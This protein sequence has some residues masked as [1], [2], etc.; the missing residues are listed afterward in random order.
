MLWGLLPVSR[1]ER[2]P[3][4]YG[5][6]R[7][8]VRLLRC[9]PAK[10]GARNRVRV[11]P[12]CRGSERSESFQLVT[13]RF[14]AQPGF[15][16]SLRWKGLWATYPVVMNDLTESQGRAMMIGVP[17]LVLL[18][19]AGFIVSAVLEGA[20]RTPAPILVP[21]AL[22]LGLGYVLLRG[23]KHA[24]AG[25]VILYGGMLAS[26]ALFFVFIVLFS[27]NSLFG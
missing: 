12:I 25:R 3:P 16:H 19:L 18:T 9:P 22:N 11:R 23:G 13:Q 17:T 20:S 8:A 10:K 15:N 27:P 24:G 1:V 7:R 14:G 26:A 4:N 6:H 5:N 21:L 2:R